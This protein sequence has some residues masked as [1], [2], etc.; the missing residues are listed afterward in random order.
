MICIISLFGL[1][2][3]YIYTWSDFKIGNY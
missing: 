2:E 3:I 1:E